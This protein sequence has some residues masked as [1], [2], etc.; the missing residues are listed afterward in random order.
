MLAEAERVARQKVGGPEVLASEHLLLG[1]GP[2][3][4]PGN[5]L[6]GIDWHGGFGQVEQAG[7]KWTPRVPGPAEDLLGQAPVGRLGSLLSV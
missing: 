2:T 4:I 7:E 1:E 3:E 6:S 5:A